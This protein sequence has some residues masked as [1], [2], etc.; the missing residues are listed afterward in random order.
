MWILLAVASLVVVAFLYWNLR[1]RFAASRIET[2]LDKRRSTSRMASAAE[3]VEGNRHLQVALAVTNA[4]LFYENADMEASLDLRWIREIEYD[5]RLA[6]G[7]AVE[8]GEVLR[9]RCDSQLF[10][11]VLPTDV[12]KRWQVALPPRGQKEVPE[13]GPGLR[14]VSAP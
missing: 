7:P 8:G 11:F 9:I 10:E 1:K 5:T 3:F 12:V 14:A 4:D 6:T 13:E 2:L